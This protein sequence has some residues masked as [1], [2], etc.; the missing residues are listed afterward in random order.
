MIDALNLTANKAK[1]SIIE[2]SEIYCE[3]LKLQ[4][5]ESEHLQCISVDNTGKAG[6]ESVKTL[7][8]QIVLLDFQL[9][10]MTGLEVAKRIKMFNELTKVFMLTAHTDVSILE[11]IID[12][13]NV[14]AVAIKG[15]YYFELNFIT[16]IHYIINN[17]TYLE[18]S[19]LSKLR[20]SNRH[21]GLASL[22]KRE[23][24]LFIQFHIGKSDKQIAADLFVDI[25]HIKNMKSKIIKKIRN[26]NL[27]GLLKKL[28]ENAGI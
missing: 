10:D 6:L 27:D 20:A 17:G 26:D 12:D 16:A 11:R 18:P 28:L 1:I 9:S 25:A 8:S 22:S 7:R 19:L 24:E 23:F 3:S 2:D 13:K 15:S 5:S 21:S 14:D 4:L